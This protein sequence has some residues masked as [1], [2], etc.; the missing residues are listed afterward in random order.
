MAPQ[1]QGRAAP[2]SLACLSSSQ[3][4]QA[5]LVSSAAKRPNPGHEQNVFCG[6]TDPGTQHAQV[7]RKWTDMS[8]LAMHIK[9]KCRWA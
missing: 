2:V 5:T 4:S 1:D 9:T 7:G 6:Q 3:R 8:T